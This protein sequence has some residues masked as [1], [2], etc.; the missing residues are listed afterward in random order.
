MSASID[1]V[2][3]M[4]RGGP[5]LY[6]NVQCSHWVCNVLKSDSYQQGD[7]ANT[8]ANAEDAPSNLQVEAESAGCGRITAGQGG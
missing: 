4:A 3:P 6:T 7:S 1:H 5:H 8:A 2:V